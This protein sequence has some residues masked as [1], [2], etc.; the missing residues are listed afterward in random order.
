MLQLHVDA[1][2]Q[3]A[4]VHQGANELGIDSL[5][6]VEIRT[7]FLKEV[8]VD[9]PLMKILGGALVGDLLEFAVEKLPQELLPKFICNKDVEEPQRLSP[10][11][12][13][14]DPSDTQSTES[15]EDSGSS[16][17]EQPARSAATSISASEEDLEIPSPERVL[18]RTE[19]MSFGQSRFWSL[20]SLLEDRTTFNIVC[21][22]NL[23]GYLRL[24]ELDEAVAIV[25]QRYEALRTCFFADELQQPRQGILQKS[26]VR[27]ESRE[28]VSQAEVTQEFEDMKS[29][30]FDL[31]Q[32]ETVRVILLSQSPTSHFMIVGYHHIV[33]D[34]VSLE[35]FLSDVQKVYNR[36]GLPSKM[37]HYPDFATRQRRDLGQGPKDN[38]M[39]FWKKEFPSIPA[40][41]PLLPFSET[42][43][44]RTM[45]RYDFN[46]VSFKIIPSLTLQIKES[47]RK[48]KVTPFHFFLAAFKTLLFRLLDTDDVCIG[49]A[50]A[51]RLDKDVLESIGNYLNLLP[52]R[53]RSQPSQNFNEALKEARTKAYAALAH[54]RVPFDVLIEQLDVPRSATHNPL[55]QAFVNYRQGVAEKRFFGECE[56]VIEQF[57]VARTG[58]DV[59]LDILDNPGGDS[60]IMF[61]VQKDLYSDEDAHTL[62]KYYVRLLET[63][64]KDSE[65]GTNEPSIFDKK[66]IQHAVDLGQGESV[67]YYL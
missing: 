44:R 45:T 24:D 2:K 37:F 19:D 30:S 62:M 27:L 6:A 35:V 55:F 59:S 50:D 63:F 56:A 48:C 34:G 21:L 32:G 49:I 54:S 39:S 52:L 29:Y 18:A 38:E 40:P 11:H 47:C 17:G 20:M 16:E 26:Q 65:M 53:F 67:L 10:S 4:I 33:M 13:G 42:R 15:P 14:K 64:A 60:T 5:I 9:M 41:L 31:E 23:K 66:E 58:Y 46:S 28:G 36:Q 43:Y 12:L 57:Q 8:E 61:M 51:N 22:A 7:W 1:T 3:E 25:G